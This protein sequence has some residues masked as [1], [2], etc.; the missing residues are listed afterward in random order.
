MNNI[1]SGSSGL[2]GVPRQVN[3]STPTEESQKFFDKSLGKTQTDR[4]ADI[5]S[6]S[7]AQTTQKPQE[8]QVKPDTL[9]RSL[10]EKDIMDQ[11]LNLKQSLTGE[12]KAIL[13]AM[14]EHG[15][16]ANSENFEL[17]RML[18]KGN[19]TGRSVESA[20]ISFSKGL[21]SAKG[22]DLLSSFFS[23]ASQLSEQ[24]VALQRQLSQFQLLLQGH[25][26]FIEQGLFIGLA[27][28]LDELDDRLKKLNRKSSDTHLN[29][30]K[31][32]R[33]ELVHGLKFLVD[34]LG[35]VEQKLQKSQHA[36]QFAQ[37]FFEQLSQ[38]KG[39]T[40][41]V[42]EL[43]ITQLILSKESTR[44]QLGSEEFMFW[45][46]VNPMAA[47]KGTIDILIQRDKKKKNTVDPEKTRI[48]LKFETPDLGEVSVIIDIENNKLWY[49][50]Q[51]SSGET[52]RLVSE[53]SSDLK[54]SMKAINFDVQGVRSLLK[55][56][57]IKK[58][59]FPTI[60]LDDL[61]R[62]QAEV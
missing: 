62:I 29:L 30:S 3:R 48:I 49:V 51:T 61:T 44:P 54:E 16:E 50:F 36:P 24:S 26:S 7:Q 20:V 19:K 1:G 18:T 12:N 32:D 11:L 27:S 23:N 28:V 41:S 46:I 34:F 43:F 35:G 57:D 56:I 10:T 21:T 31:T 59:L 37:A 15:V 39:A 33:G 9:A 58:Y 2:S 40:R 47:A 45:Q 42:L 4:A 14:I 25:R 38:F 8:A 52:K 60:N 13:M 22:V 55:K 6:T 17:I 53:M 5:K